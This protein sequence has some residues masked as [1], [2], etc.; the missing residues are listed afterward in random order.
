MDEKII[1]QLCMKTFCEYPRNVERCTVGQGN[2]VFIVE[3]ADEK[4]VVRCSL[5]HNAYQ[6]TVTWLKR[7]ASIDVPVPEV[8]AQGKIEEYGCTAAS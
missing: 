2:Y 6:N 1:S 4:K 5:E 8:L 7:L 3:F